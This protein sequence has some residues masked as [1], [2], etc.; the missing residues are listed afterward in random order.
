MLS[1][2]A[3]LLAASQHPSEITTLKQQAYLWTSQSRDLINT[4]PV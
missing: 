2:V 1:T 4:N 3:P